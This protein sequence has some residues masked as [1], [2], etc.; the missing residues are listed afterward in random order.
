MKRKLC[1]LFVVTAIVFI[2]VI[3][4]QAIFC[5]KCGTQ[6]PDDGVFCIKCGT[7]LIHLKG[8]S[9]SD[10]PTKLLDQKKGKG[11]IF[12][13]ATELLWRE[14]CDEAISL[15]ENSFGPNPN[16]MKAKVSLAK[17]YLAKCEMLKEKGN[18]QYKSL[19][20]RPLEIGRSI[21]HSPDG[22]YI[23]AHAF[24]I[25]NRPERARK[26]ANKAI[27]MSISPR[28]E[29][30]FVLGDSWVVTH[31][32]STAPPGYD[33]SPRAKK[34]YE[35]VINMNVSNDVKGLAYYKLAVMFSESG[36]K[37]KA[38]NALKSGL[39]LAEREALVKRIR[40]MQ[41]SM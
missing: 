3:P 4:A 29:Y 10:Q 31:T 24:L 25:N 41:E 19:A 40:V 34:A 5:S 32:M 21:L 16:D 23:C 20:F 2:F 7:K 11:A 26:Y 27:K 12:D 6:N 39:E 35:E 9:I 33:V 15:I 8:G 38:K 37:E 14:K 18:K 1:I 13:Q 22:N 36:R 28:P 17:A 30:Y